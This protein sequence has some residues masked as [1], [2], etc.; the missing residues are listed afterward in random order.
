MDYVPQGPAAQDGASG[1]KRRGWPG[2]GELQAYNTKGS[3][4]S[5]FELAFPIMKVYLLIQKDR[6]YLGEQVVSL[7]YDFQTSGM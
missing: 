5:K 7:V 2:R 3:K 1:E 4:N 6:T